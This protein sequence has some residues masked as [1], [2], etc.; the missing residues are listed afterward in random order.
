M[1]QLFV[2]LVLFSALLHAVWNAFLHVSEDRVA[3]LGTMSV[4]YLLFGAALALALPLPPAPAW[5]YVA[6]SAL[7]ELGYCVALLRAYRSGEFSQIYPIARGLSPLAV[8]ALALVVLGEQPTP[9]ALAGIA[10]VSL[11]IV[12]LAFKRGFRFSGD[13]VPYAILTGL[14]IAAYSVVDGRGVRLGGD[15]LAYVAWVYLLWNAPQF[16]LICRLRGGLRAV[17][18]TRA[19]VSR[20]LVAGTLSLAAYAIAIVAY[21]H[22]PVATVSALRETSSIFAV[23]IGW[24]ALRERPNARRLA[25]CAMVV[26]G[27]MLIRL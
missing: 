19:A 10:L 27:A 16:A 21:R 7:L 22:L 1:D 4:P 14:F 8:C 25:A 11:G 13:S 9:Y 5:P 2:L 12:S 24:F 3:Q 26:A 18:G 17:V 20:G 15:P 6:A 23:A